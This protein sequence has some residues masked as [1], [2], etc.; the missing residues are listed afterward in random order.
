MQDFRRNVG[1]GNIPPISSS[2]CTSARVKTLMYLFVQNEHAVLDL[3][4]KTSV[5]TFAMQCPA[6]PTQ[7]ELDA[8]QL[9][10]QDVTEI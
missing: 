2:D 10:A 7:I 1:V 6:S 4:P 8:R 3:C 5:M 9:S